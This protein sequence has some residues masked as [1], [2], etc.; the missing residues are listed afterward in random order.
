MAAKLPHEPEAGDGE[1]V[2]SDP[3]SAV[4]LDDS[5]EFSLTEVCVACRV[6]E[7]NSSSRS[8]RKV[9]SSLREPI[10]RS[11]VSPVLR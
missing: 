5:V 1:R 7:E 6:S 9:S 3:I 4:L 11:G 2:M 10:A 8:S